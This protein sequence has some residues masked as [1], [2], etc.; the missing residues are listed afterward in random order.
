MCL[1]PHA[2]LVSPTSQSS[3]S[4]VSGMALKKAVAAGVGQGEIRRAVPES[5]SLEVGVPEQV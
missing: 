3:S 2:G 1:R 4:K 5:S